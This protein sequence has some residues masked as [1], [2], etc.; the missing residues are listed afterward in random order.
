MFNLSLLNIFDEDISFENKTVSLST[1]SRTYSGEEVFVC[2]TG[3]SFDGF[4]FIDEVLEKKCEVVIFKS[5]EENILKMEKHSEKYSD[6]TFIGVDS[7]LVALQEIA[8]ERIKEFKSLGGY[9][10]GITGSNGK[11]TTKEMLT[12]LLKAAF[13]SEVHSTKGNFNNHIGVPLTILSADKNCKYMIV[14]MGSNHLGEIQTLCEI[15]KPE[16]GI[17]SSVGA[18]HIGLFGNIDNIFKE[19]KSLFDYVKNND[20][21]NSKFVV[22]GDDAYLGKIPSDEI[23]IKF[24]KSE[25]CCPAFS[26]GE[27][28]IND[29]VVIK[30][31]NIHEKYNLNNLI[32]ALLL[33]ISVFPEKKEQFITAANE[34]KIPALNRSEWIDK[35]GKKIFLDAYNANPTSMESSLYSFIENIAKVNISLEETLFVL[36]DMNELGEYTESEHK[37]IGEILKTKNAKHVAFV[38]GFSNYYDNG[39]KDGHVYL[40]KSQLE[41]A[42]PELSKKCKAIFIK[43]SRS[44]QL[45]SLIDIT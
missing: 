3:E 35:N 31:V 24:G 43:A 39:F 2:L 28:R 27:V 37:R 42:W 12:E 22:N 38:G 4:N 23:L 36:G 40:E 9:V 18:A 15:A 20:L 8:R 29:S 11:T 30:N 41:S 10:F 13:G 7:P 26:D 19:K 25:M 16:Y 45:E 34:Y 1:D 14:E 33:S 44:L 5:S 32:S 21:G 6:V 17:I